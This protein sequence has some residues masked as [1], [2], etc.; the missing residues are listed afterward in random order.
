MSDKIDETC[1]YHQDVR[2]NV[3]RLTELAFNANSWQSRF[4]EKYLHIE[5]CLL[6][7]QESQTKVMDYIIN[8]SKN[9]ETNYVTKKEFDDYKKEL[10]SNIRWVIGISVSA[11]AIVLSVIQWV[12]GIIKTTNI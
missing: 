10:N 7:I 5:K 3:D 4:E 11:G 2:K 8:L 6:N 9:I 12:Y 1:V